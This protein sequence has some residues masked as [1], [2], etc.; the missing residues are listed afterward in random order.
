MHESE[1]TANLSEQHD[2]QKKQSCNHPVVAY[3]K[4]T[5]QHQNQQTNL[6]NTLHPT[7]CNLHNKQHPHLPPPN[8]FWKQ[9]PAYTRKK[10]HQL[11]SKH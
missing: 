6:Q 7:H 1:S 9:L 3:A 5:T 11:G 10:M 8:V 2:K 4:Q